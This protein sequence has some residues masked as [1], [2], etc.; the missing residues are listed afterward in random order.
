M[1]TKKLNPDPYN[2][3]IKAE[4][5]WIQQGLNMNGKTKPTNRLRLNKFLAKWA[6][7]SRRQADKIIKKGEVFVN[8][9]KILQ[10][11]VFVDP[12]KDSVRIK[13]QPIY[14]KKTA[15][16]YLMFNK[17]PK[18]LSTSQDPKGRPIVM[19]YI[20]KHKERLFLVGRLDWDSEGLLILTNDGDFSDKVLHP[21][22]KIPKTYF[23]KVKGCPKNS[24]IEKLIQGVSTSVGKRRAL[25]AK[26]L[27]T[28]SLSNIWIKLIIGEGKKRQIRLMFDKL[29]FPVRQLKRTAIGRLKINKL[30]KGAFVR[31]SDKDIQKIFQWPKELKFFRDLNK[32]LNPSSQTKKPEI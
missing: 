30:A 12:K 22:N 19:D 4:R 18:V 13:N 20:P 3:K 5:T 27:S 21:K 23:V 6:G 31:L 29:G 25:F 2:S 28:K 15:S 8:D 9:K 7:V 10:L 32:P 17:P 1:K 16:I 24:Q 14:F 26:K 11:A